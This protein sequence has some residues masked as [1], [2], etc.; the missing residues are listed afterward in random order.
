MPRPGSNKKDREPAVA[1]RRGRYSARSASCETDLVAAQRLR[2]LVFVD[3][4]G[5]AA[6][7]GGIERDGFDDIS[8]HIL[9]EETQTG[10]LV[11]C[12]R[13]LA[14]ESGREISR[15]YAAQYYDLNALRQF[16]QR[17]AEVGRFCIRPG[18]CDP[19]I[20]RVAWGAMTR[21]V[22]AEGTRLLFGCSS[23]RG[24]DPAAYRD[25]FGLLRARHLGPERWLPGI[26]AA[27]VVRFA[28]DVQRA[29][30]PRRAMQTLP[31]LLRTYLTMGG[32]VSDHAVVDAE[33]NTLH[34]FTGLEIGSIPARRARALRAVAG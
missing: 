6:G 2:H 18:C 34:V 22:D 11:C 27:Q 13:L 12:Y 4:G 32:W 25:A 1:L 15:S 17:M 5:A 8:R 33:M 14:L 23:F 16:P 20:L 3:I 30:D 10:R 9:V 29:P 24:T 31:P 21:F 26:K 7:T 28:G 19:D